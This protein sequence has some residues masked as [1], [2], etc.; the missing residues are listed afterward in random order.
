VILGAGLRGVACLVLACTGLASPQDFE[1]SEVRLNR[2]G[3]VEGSIGLRPGGRLEVRNSTFREILLVANYSLS[4]R[5]IDLLGQELIVGG[6]TW[7]DADRFDLVAK[8]DSNAS[9]GAIQALLQA[10]LAQSFRLIS[11]REPRVMGAYAL[12]AGRRVKLDKA[13]PGEATGCTLRA[14]DDGQVHRECHNM[15]MTALANGL[16]GMASY[17]IDQPVVDHTGLTGAYDFRLDWAPM[18]RAESGVGG[19]PIIGD[20]AGATIFD[21]IGRLGLKLEEG[22]YPVTVVVI[23]HVERLAA[24]K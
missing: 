10:I 19:P 21:S 11:H 2:S 17:Y 15:T 18:R 14:S 12:R 24:V 4:K 3:G 7:I 9:P 13:A 1:A 8:A 5:L 23:D 22:R 6:P 20:A 16:P